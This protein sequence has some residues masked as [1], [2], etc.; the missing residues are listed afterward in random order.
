[1]LFVSDPH[2]AVYGL[3]SY[4]QGVDNSVEKIIKNKLSLI[5]N[6][7]FFLSSKKNTVEKNCKS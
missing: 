4:P 1:M 2:E 6:G 5:L 3:K 7:I